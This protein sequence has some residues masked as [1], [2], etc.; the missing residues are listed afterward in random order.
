MYLFTCECIYKH[1]GRKHLLKH[2]AYLDLTV[3]TVIKAEATRLKEV[4]YL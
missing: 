1:K 4:M 2:V 3:R